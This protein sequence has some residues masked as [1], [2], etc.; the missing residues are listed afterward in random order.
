MIPRAGAWAEIGTGGETRR[1]EPVI[2]GG[3]LTGI[4]IRAKKT[5]LKAPM[6]FFTPLGA[7]FYDPACWQ[8]TKIHK[9]Q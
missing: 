1:L 4:E 6:D 5:V 9:G 8:E 7:F 3:D 2:R